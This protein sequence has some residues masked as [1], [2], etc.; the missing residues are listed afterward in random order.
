[1]D[2]MSFVYNKETQER[3]ENTMKKFLS[4]L[5]AVAML[6][7]LLPVAFAEAVPANAIP[8]TAG[9]FLLYEAETYKDQ[10]IANGKAISLNNAPT[11]EPLSGNAGVYTGGAGTSTVVLTLP[12]TAA[13]DVQITIE[14]VAGIAGHLSYPY[15]AVDGTKIFTYTTGNGTSAGFNFTANNDYPAMKHT[16]TAIIPKGTHNLTF[17]IPARVANGGTV[18]FALDYIKLTTVGVVYPFVFPEGAKATASANGKTAVVTYDNTAVRE[19][20]GTKTYAPY[21]KVDIRTFGTLTDMIVYSKMYETEKKADGTIAATHSRH[22]PLTNLENGQFYALIYPLASESDAGISAPLTTE[23]FTVSNRPIPKNVIRVEAENNWQ[24]DAK[25]VVDSAFASDGKL[26]LASQGDQWHTS[27]QFPRSG[28]TSPIT[29]TM[30]VTIPK[31]GTYDIEAALS[32]PQGASKSFLSEAV[33]KLDGEEILSNHD[34]VSGSLAINGTFPW[35]TNP[36]AKFKT[37]MELEAKTYEITYEF[38]VPTGNTTQ[39][40]LFSADYIQ[41]A[42]ADDAAYIAGNSTTTVEAEDYVSYFVFDQVDENGEST[43]NKPN[44][45]RVQ[46]SGNASDGAY[47]ATDSYAADDKGLNM[48]ASIPIYVEKSGLYQFEMLDSAAGSNGNLKLDGTTTIVSNIASGKTLSSQGL[49]ILDSVTEKWSYFDAKY[50]SARTNTATIYMTE[51]AHTLDFT[52]LVRGAGNT[53]VSMDYLR[54]TPIMPPKAAISANGG[55]IELDEYANFFTKDNKTAA[56]GVVVDDAKSANG[57]R[58]KVTEIPME[59]GAYLDIPVTVEKTGWY[60]VDAILSYKSGNYTSRITIS[61]DGNPVLVNTAENPDRTDLSEGNTYVDNSYPMYRFGG[62]VYVTAGDHVINVFAKSR[63]AYA[64][65]TQK[66]AD[67][68]LYRVCFHADNIVFTPVDGKAVAN[69][70]DVTVNAELLENADGKLIIAAYKGNEMVGVK[71]EDVTDITEINN[72]VS[73]TAKPDTVKVMVWEN[74]EN[75]VPVVKVLEIK[76]R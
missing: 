2:I 17:N 1:M 39:P 69:G 35:V 30:N 36:M 31:A 44:D 27:Y 46:Y 76:V 55:T 51:G 38:Y 5:L 61:V 4:A 14:T 66:E 72:T 41:F 74:L 60:N 57:K 9:E 28:A 75:V 71:T 13:A 16:I 49:D 6:V 65:D 19:S 42:P 21:Y 43:N 26:I 58:M 24:Y 59:S 40:Y 63:E 52:Y 64:D 47:F 11:T 54:F 15:W 20:D 33:V 48:L 45:A 25:F 56:N 34:T 10:F 50:H 73:C 29:H 32:N 8:E 23:P 3:E 18:A 53:T 68:G 70:N 37:S 67:K 12:I 62:C 7:T 22:I